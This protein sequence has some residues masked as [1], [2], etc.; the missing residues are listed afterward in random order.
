MSGY[1]NAAPSEPAPG[2]RW[3]VWADG[4]TIGTAICGLFRAVGPQCRAIRRAAWSAVRFPAVPDGHDI[5]KPL[6][7]VHAVDDAIV[8]DA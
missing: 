5:N 1:S 7:V 2:T 6:P 4:F 3:S 8:T